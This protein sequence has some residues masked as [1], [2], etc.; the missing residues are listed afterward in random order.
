[1]K[2]WTLL[3]LGLVTLIIVPFVLFEQSVEAFMA[4]ILEH[5]TG[6]ELAAFLIA[7]LVADVLLPVPSSLVSSYACHQY[8]PALG[9]SIIFVGMT[10]AIGLSYGLGRSLGAT[11]TRRTLGERSYERAVV[12]GR[13]R[14]AEWVVA[15]S[16]AIPVLSEAVG[17]LAGALRWPLGSTLLWASLANAGVAGAYALFFLLLGTEA[18]GGAVLGGSIVVPA[19]GMALGVHLSRS[20]SSVDRAPRPAVDAESVQSRV[21]RTVDDAQRRASD[22]RHSSLK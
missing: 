10:G 4:K 19:L 14:R 9:F 15:L 11:G 6:V 13:G 17:F 8:G 5:H 7:A 1:M 12:F 21:E 22:S 2:R 3:L 20:R 16:R 18:G